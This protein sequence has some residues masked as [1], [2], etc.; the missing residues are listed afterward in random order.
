MK[1]SKYV[2]DK[3]DAKQRKMKEIEEFILN[4]GDKGVTVK[5]LCERFKTAS[6]TTGKYVTELY[7]SGV[8]AKKDSGYPYKYIWRQEEKVNDEDIVQ[9]LDDDK[10]VELGGVELDVVIPAKSVDQRDV[11]YASSRSGGGKFFKYLVL[12]PWENKAT[13]IGIFDEGHPVL[14]FN[15]TQFIYIG[16]DPE[17]GKKMYADLSNVCSRGN[18]TFGKKVIKISVEYMDAVKYYLSRY[19][20]IKTN[21]LDS[22]SDLKVKELEDRLKASEETRKKLVSDLD[23]E[24]KNFG[25]I[26]QEKDNDH[27]MLLEEHKTRLIE[28]DETKQMLTESTESLKDA[29]DQIDKLREE[30]DNAE[31]RIEQLKKELNENP[32]KDSDYVKGLEASVDALKFEYA[33]LEAANKCLTDHNADLYKIVIAA[34]G[35]D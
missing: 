23:R 7:K 33:S 28:L 8:I 13:V 29:C 21:A 24:R 12:T 4:S 17:T 25:Q 10:S 22:S 3:M 6:S 30:L 11:I 1:L 26:C 9:E 18:M 35:K 5:E 20:R 32:A 34:L 31:E 19:Y 2:M 27:K 14:N 16:N 15:S